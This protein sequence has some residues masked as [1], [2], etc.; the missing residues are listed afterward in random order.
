MKNDFIIRF[1]HKKD[2][3]LILEFIKELASYEKMLDT[4]I[5]SE[6]TLH[7]TLFQKKYAEVVIAELQKNPIGFALFFT[8]YSGYQGKPNIYIEDLFITERFRG[9]G[10]GKKM[11]SF[12]ANLALER[13]CGRVEWCVFNWN[14]KA[15]TFYDSLGAKAIDTLI[16]YRLTGSDLQTCANS[17]EKR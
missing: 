1:A 3:P 17:G 7:E 4:V 5:S 13:N 8:S 11:F 6:K 16:I 14:K 12:I 10:Y 15:I 9:R 2:V